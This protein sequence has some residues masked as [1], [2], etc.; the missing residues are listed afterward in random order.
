MSFPS[1]ITDI[2]A[3]TIES[4]SGKIADNVLKNNALLSRLEKKENVRPFDGGSQILEE[5]SFAQNGNAAWYSGYDLLPV[6]QQDVL[7]AAT[8]SIKQIACPVVVSGLEELQNSGKEK[9]IDLVEQR[10]KV[11]EKTMANLMAQGV[12]SDGTGFGGKQLVGLGA[13]VIATPG[14][15][16]YGGIDPSVWTFWQNAV[17]NFG[18]ATSATIQGAMNTLW[19]NLVRGSDRPD[20]IMADTA[21]WGIFT[22]SLQ[23][24]QRFT[25]SKTADLGFQSLKFM[26]ADVV[27]DG[28]IG[29]FGPSNVMFFLN[30]DYLFLR[31]HKNRN[32]VPLSKSRQ[33]VNQDASVEIMAWAGAF[34]VSGREF[35]GYLKLS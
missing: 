12:Y 29:G 31:P 32:M 6:A 17:N 26:D 33:A 15:G 16:V 10:M 3:T 23:S 20:L 34:T 14:T 8:Y 35:Q 22:A 19:G 2:V 1:S 5:L 7:S 11:A 24:Q 30:T 18:A 4:R 27:L 25:D 28:G 9:I 13:A 21:S